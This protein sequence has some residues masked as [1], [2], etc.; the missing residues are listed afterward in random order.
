MEFIFYV[1]T[2]F[3]D[4]IKLIIILEILLN[5]LTIFGIYI[6]IDFINSV[7]GPIY[8]KIRSI[9]P[10]TVWIFDFAPMVVFVIINI[11][12]WLIYNLLFT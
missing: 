7:T 4:I 10:T 8:S 1:I 5:L 11:L 9:M 2:T 12:E 3:L 6:K